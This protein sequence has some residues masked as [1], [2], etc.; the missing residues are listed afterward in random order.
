[1]P[2]GLVPLATPP[3]LRVFLLLPAARHTCSSRGRIRFL[4]GERR[5]LSA[6]S[7]S[8]SDHPLV[9]GLPS[10]CH[11][12]L[13]AATLCLPPGGWVSYSPGDR[14]PNSIDPWHTTP[15]HS[16][17]LSTER[18]NKREK[19]RERER[20][21]Q[22]SASFNYPFGRLARAR[23]IAATLARVAGPETRSKRCR[24]ESGG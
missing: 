9:P 13:T 22:S 3:C 14:G 16:T 23:K 19:S 7:L 20:E 2:T 4:V 12:P 17:P 15:R 24:V 10:L 11:Q 18:K 1:M 21:E 5:S 8:S 6:P